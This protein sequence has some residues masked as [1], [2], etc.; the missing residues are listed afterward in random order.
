MKSIRLSENLT[1]LTRFGVVNA[2]VVQEEDG[3]T[4]VDTMV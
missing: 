4:V 1:Q 3:L 2:F